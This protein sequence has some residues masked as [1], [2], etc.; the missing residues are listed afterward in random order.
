LDYIL[1][2]MSYNSLHGHRTLL[3]ARTTLEI[4]AEILKLL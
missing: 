4:M 3:A 1:T 2:Y